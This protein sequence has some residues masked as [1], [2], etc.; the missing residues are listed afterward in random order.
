MK[1]CWDCKAFLNKDLFY[2]NKFKK[3]GLCD[4]CKKCRNKRNK[5]WLE[6]NKERDK[7][8]HLKWRTKNPDKTK[9]YHA[10][11]KAKP[12]SKEMLRKKAERYRKSGIYKI[13]DR[14]RYLARNISLQPC[15]ICGTDKK[16]ER[17]HPDYNKALYVVFLCKKH[18][19]DVERQHIKCPPV[20]AL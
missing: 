15:Q 16:I 1:K 7:I 4:D 2:R 10:A 6:N 11:W 12:G 3:D 18:H 5:A 19:I 13:Q 9:R 14:A 17:H 20:Q 8:N